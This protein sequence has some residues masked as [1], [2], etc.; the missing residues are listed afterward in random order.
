M[1]VYYPMDREEHRR[2]LRYKNRNTLWLRYGKKSLKG[3]SMS[4]ADLGSDSHPPTCYINYFKRVKMNTAQNGTLSSDFQENFYRNNQE[5]RLNKHKLIPI[6][7]LHG[8]C[9]SRTSQSGSCRDLASH[10]YI[11]FSIDHHDG[12][13]HFS[14][15]QNGKEL[16]WPLNQNATDMKYR[17]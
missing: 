6:I 16:Y 17:E 7:L 1:S 13:A 14:Q 11:V 9:G 12:S 15:K 10:G 5:E 8:L 3:I 2:T 4:L